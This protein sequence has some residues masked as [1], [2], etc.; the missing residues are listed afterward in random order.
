MAHFLSSS[1]LMKVLILF[2]LLGG[3]V[4]CRAHPPQD[5]C[6]QFRT[7]IFRVKGQ[8]HIKIRRT[9][10]HQYEYDAK[11]KIRSTY[12]IE[13][14]DSCHYTLIMIHTTGKRIDYYGLIGIVVPHAIIKSGNNEYTY[15][16]EYFYMIRDRCGP[17]GTTIRKEETLIKTE[18]IPK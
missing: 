15:Y 10:K 2:L 11:E 7:G 8:E 14:T 12:R 17:M 3:P 18:E 6:S 1:Y 16:T 4:L 5:S 9:L 13:W